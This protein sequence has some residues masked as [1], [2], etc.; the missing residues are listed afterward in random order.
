MSKKPTKLKDEDWLKTPVQDLSPAEA[1][2]RFYRLKE[3][4]KEQMLL[5]ELENVGILFS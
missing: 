5:E 4:E 2:E 1:L 3:I